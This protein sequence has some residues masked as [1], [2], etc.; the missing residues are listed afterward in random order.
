MFG[1][2]LTLKI[3]FI[4]PNFTLSILVLKTETLENRVETLF[5]T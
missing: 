1:K 4:E 2:L 3:V 5:G